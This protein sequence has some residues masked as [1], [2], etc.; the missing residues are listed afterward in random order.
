[1]VNVPSPARFALHKLVVSQRRPAT[2]HAKAK[3]D[4]LQA[5]QIIACLLDQRPG[6]LWLALDVAADHPAPKFRKTMADGI[7]MLD[8]E[9]RK[10][11]ESYHTPP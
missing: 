5:A 11:L 3:K 8:D 1:M 10:P 6:D 9:L 4:V 7:A 2:E